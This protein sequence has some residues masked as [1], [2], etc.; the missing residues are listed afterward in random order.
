M[1]KYDAIV[2][3]SGQAGPF[4]AA[5]LAGEGQRVALIER[6]KL[7]GT[8]IN[9]GCTP[10]KTLRKSAR[11]AHV[12]RTAG[13]YG[14][15]AGEVKVDF[16]AAMDRMHER[17]RQSRTGLEGW[18]GAMDNLDI[19]IGQGKFVGRGDD[20][21]F[22]VSI[23]DGDPISSEQVYINTGTRPFVPPVPGL[24]EVPHLTNRELLQLTECPPS[25]IVLGGSY[26]GLELGQIF[27]RLGSQVSVVE[28]GPRL[29]GREDVDVSEALQEMLEGEGL[30]LHLGAPVTSVSKD[31]EGIS[32][33]LEGGTVVSGSHLLV[34]TGRVPNTEDLGLASVGVETDGRGYIQTNGALETSTP[35]IF[36]LGDVNRRGAFTHTSYQ[37][38]EIVW[39]NRNGATRSADDRTMAYAMFT[40]PPLGHVGIH[41]SDAEK[42]VAD[43]RSLSLASIDMKNVSRAKEEGETIGKMKMWIDEESGHILGAT[44]LGIQADEIIQSLSLLMGA[45]GTIQDVLYTLPVH[46]TVTEFFPTVLARRAPFMAPSKEDA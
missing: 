13:A 40:D 5:K 30:R 43:G 22:L 23:N 19:H 28:V 37:D 21:A 2:I 4:L 17:V 25:L 9:R 32:L 44:I 11:V 6:E 41:Q 42:L 34:A 26:I 35:G 38:Y 46:P 14:I 10:T 8:C 16:R 24:S 12:C 3:G 45:K 33:H 1:T 31:G 18:L 20:G 36:A 15:N 39:A 7:G 29:A 27:S